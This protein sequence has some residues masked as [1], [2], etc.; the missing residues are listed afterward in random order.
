M[1][2]QSTTNAVAPTATH[3]VPA[4]LWLGNH[5]FLVQ[6]T[7]NFLR[8]MFCASDACTLCSVCRKIEEEQHHAALWLAPEKELYTLE[9]IELIH[10]TIAYKLADGEHYF[11]IVQKADS[12]S[13]LCANSLLKSIEEPPAGYHFILL[14]ER[15]DMIVPT[16]RSRC[17]TEAHY[18]NAAPAIHPLL[19]FFYSRENNDSI[20]FLKE[21]ESNKIGEQES[22]QL[23]DAL[24][25]YWIEEAKKAIINNQRKE[26]LHACTVIETMKQTFLKPPMPG[27][28]KLFWKNL[29]LQFHTGTCS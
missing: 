10:S 9:Q 19:R 22:L 2:Y 17:Q 12:L 6:K 20:A 16:I 29:F 15:A 4:Y 8:A 27:S 7:K 3:R 26:Y 13:P 23:L 1:D 24:L 18:G 5:D 11:F 25:Y 14:A 28:S 21:I